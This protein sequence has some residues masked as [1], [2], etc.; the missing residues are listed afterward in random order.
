MLASPHFT[1][2]MKGLPLFCSYYHV[3]EVPNT[4]LTCLVEWTC[5]FFQLLFRIIELF[6]LNAE[7]LTE[8]VLV[9]IDVVFY[10]YDVINLHTCI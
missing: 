4:L 9:F 2:L 1:G 5:T 10:L 6:G 7:K 8:S 3:C